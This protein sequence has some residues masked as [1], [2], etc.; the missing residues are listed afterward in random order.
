MQADIN[1]EIVNLDEQLDQV[2]EKNEK[3]FLMAYRFHMLKVQ[4]ELMQLKKKAN[5]T[6]LKTLQ[7]AKLAELNKEMHRFQVDCME[8]RRYCDEQEKKVKALDFQKG[9]LEEDQEFLDF[10]LR[11]GREQN[12]VLKLAL[13]KNLAILDEQ[14]FE[15]ENARDSLRQYIKSV[16]H[17]L[18]EAGV[19]G[20][21]EQ[22]PF[23]LQNQSPDIQDAAAREQSLE[24]GELHGLIA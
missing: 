5:E 6:E 7:D 13:S 23:A 20:A 14:S 11:D 8:V 1:E 3:D 19:D 21:L 15:N 12:A 22:G 17:Q 9:I 24:T 10:E 16:E 4:T 2:L 18:G